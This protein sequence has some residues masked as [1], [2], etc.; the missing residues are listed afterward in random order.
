VTRTAAGSERDLAVCPGTMPALADGFITRPG[1]APGLARL[2]P[3]TAVALV[4]D[5]AAQPGPSSGSCGKTQLAVHTARALRESGLADLVA[6]IDASSRAS[7]LSG[8]AQ[9]AAAAGIDG[10][11]P[12]EETAARLTGWLAE[13]IRPWLVILDDLRD[14]ADLDG[15]WPRGHAGRALITTRDPQAIAGQPGGLAVRVVPVG[16][17]TTREAIS[18]L[19][20][21]LAADPGQRHGAIDLALALDGDPLAL[22]YASAVIATTTQSCADYQHHYTQLRA[23]VGQADGGPLAASAVTWLLSAERAGQ[24]SPG[25]ATGLLLALAAQLDSPAIPAPVLTTQAACAYLADSGASAS[26]PDTA[27]AAVR[28][29]EATGLLTLDMT[30]TPPLAWMSRQLAAHARTGT[31]ER[32]ARRAA[33]AAADSLLE[34]WPEHDSPPWLAT[35]AR[36]CAAGLQHAA[37]GR[38]WTA[39]ACHP[40]L[41]RAGHSLASSGL[42]GPAVRHWTQIADTSQQILGPDHPATVTAVTGLARAL[43]AA[44]QHADAAWWWQQAAA[45]HARLSG[46]GHPATLTAR[47][48]TGQAM[49]AAGR[50]GDAITILEHAVTDCERA[51]GPRHRDTLTARRA[52]AAACQADDQPGRAIHGYRRILA[53]CEHAHGSRSL[54]ATTARE[55]LAAACQAAGRVTEAISG[56]RTALADHQRAMGAG[57]PATIVARRRLAAACQA[58][59][60]ITAA[61]GFHDEACAASTRA[62]GD[63]HP[64]TL[65]CRADLAAA[66]AAAGRLADAAALLRDTLARCDLA[67]PPGAPLTAAVRH[68][69]TGLAGP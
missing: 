3:G 37:A 48:A 38:L 6:W 62:L 27:R 64:D 28:A 8:Y 20:N 12:A 54:A 10:A 43:Q 58:A 67:L 9:A 26:D 56:Y 15:L 55:D 33:G 66:Y 11:G 49:C 34:I 63:D 14:A 52:L 29:L 21:R 47:I 50:P 23:R 40:V 19:R 53:D 57:H 22:A 39:G 1:S 4:S 17:F 16:P 60:N 68:A 61:L 30:T 42:T 46:P 31:P 5:T 36:S 41:L 32:L 13:T 35:I 18:Y 25:G 59:G 44:G 69:L 7:A 45:R 65:A 51:R 2:A 24:L